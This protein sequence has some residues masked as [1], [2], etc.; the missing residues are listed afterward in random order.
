MT[1]HR[2]PPC[3]CGPE[4][5]FSASFVQMLSVILQL[6]FGVQQKNFWEMDTQTIRKTN[7]ENKFPSF[8]TL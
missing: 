6:Q 3:L 7:E 1:L 2:N 4:P 8:P 5:F